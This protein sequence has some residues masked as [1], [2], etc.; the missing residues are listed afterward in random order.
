MASSSLDIINTLLPSF[1]VDPV[2]IFD[3]DYVQLF[4]DARAIKAVVK[5]QAKVMEHPVESGA[6]VTDHRIILPVEIDLSLIIAA[7]DYQ[8]VYKAIR[9]YYFNATLLVVQTRSG[10][11]DNQVISALP[12]EEDPTMYDALQIALS[13]KQVFFVAAQYGVV[14]RH[15]SNTNTVDRGTQQGTPVMPGSTL[16]NGAMAGMKKIK[17][18]VNP[19]FGGPASD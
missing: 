18:Y 6:V 4:R 1:A 10:I 3:Q 11:Y 13:L 16:Y 8:S 5:E 14:P 12:H 15:A 2:A 19:Y 9:Q 7:T 17:T